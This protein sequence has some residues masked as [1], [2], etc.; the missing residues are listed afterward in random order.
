VCSGFAGSYN[1]SAAS[2]IDPWDDT[3]GA[4]SLAYTDATH[5]RIDGHAFEILVLD[6][7]NTHEENLMTIKMT[8]IHRGPTLVAG[9]LNELEITDATGQRLDL[10]G[11]QKIFLCRCGGSTTKPYCDGTH[12]KIGFQT[13]EEA[14]RTKG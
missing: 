10:T 2:E 14:V 12:S 11:K 4:G 6:S 8:I 13:A 5:I 9:D 7:R 1:E 3:A